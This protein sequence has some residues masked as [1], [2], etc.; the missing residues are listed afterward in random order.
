MNFLDIRLAESLDLTPLTERLIQGKGQP[1]TLSRTEQLELWDRL[2]VLSME[3]PCLVIL[4]NVFICW[5]S[6][7]TL[8]CTLLFYDAGFTKMVSSLWAMTMLNLYIRVQVNILGRHLYIDTA[9]GLESPLLLVR[10]MISVVLFFDIVKYSTSDIIIV[11][12]AFSL[13]V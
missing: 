11:C 4:I 5:L 1:N 7:I 13:L 6:L 9:R 2:K 3:Q 10:M 8:A 12:G